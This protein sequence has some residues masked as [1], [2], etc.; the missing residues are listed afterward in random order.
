M[1][2]YIPIEHSFAQ[3]EKLYYINCIWVHGYEE[4]VGNFQKKGIGKKLIKAAEDDIRNRGAKG[5][6]A[7]G[8]SL[9]FWMT[10]SW[11]QKQGY[12]KVDEESMA[13]LL[14]KPFSDDAIA[15]KWIKRKKK[16]EKIAGKVSVTA[17]LN[18]WCPSQNIVFERAK[19]AASEFGDEVV[20]TEI[21]TFNRDV[22]LEWGIADALF[23]DGKEIENGPP[24]AY[25][26]IKNEIV[27]RVKKLK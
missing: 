16:P 6:V 21:D 13:V 24:P 20:F 7:W 10:A 25:E 12:E 8:V 19:R 15:P 14:W 2:Q 11:F 3:G 18:G 26:D 22:F 4:G 23:I 1:I 9:P 27:K 17:F 5:I